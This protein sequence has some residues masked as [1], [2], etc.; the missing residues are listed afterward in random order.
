MRYLGVDYGERRVGLSYGD[1]LGV[2][3]PLPA[4]VDADPDKRWAA[5]AEVMRQRRVQEVVVGHPLNMDD[6]PGFKAKEAEAYAQRIRETF[7][8]PVHLVDERLTSYAAEETIPKNK[9]RD[10]RASGLIDSRCA[11]LILQDYLNQILPEPPPPEEL[12]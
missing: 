4:L 10:V 2:A 6:T 8:V 3:T 1:E 5:L 9:R 11:T 12:A 7:S